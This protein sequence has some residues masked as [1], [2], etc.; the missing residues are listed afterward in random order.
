MGRASIFRGKIDG[1]RIQAIVTRDGRRAFDRRRAA[2]ARLWTEV[3]GRF[4]VGISDADTVEYLARGE[5]ATE[6]YIRRHHV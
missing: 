3:T 6:D 5:A 4:A 2:L 1:P